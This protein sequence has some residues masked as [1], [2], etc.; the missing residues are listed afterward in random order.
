[1]RVHQ[2]KALTG[3]T[4]AVG[5]IEHRQMLGL[6]MWRALDRHGAAAVVV[7]DD[8]L[9]L[10]ESECFEHVEVGIIELRVG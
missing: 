8:D 6:Q 2:D 3:P 9:V 4:A 10:G 1:M 5:T 7:C